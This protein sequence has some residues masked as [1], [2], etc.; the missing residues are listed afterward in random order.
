MVQSTT[1]TKQSAPGSLRASK[2]F[3][4]S[5]CSTEAERPQFNL[6]I[7]CK[8]INAIKLSQSAS[9]QKEVYFC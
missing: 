8:L 1:N 9:P 7:H 2:Y 4:N 5:V 6:I 3:Y